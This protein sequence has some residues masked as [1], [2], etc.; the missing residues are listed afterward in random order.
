MDNFKYIWFSLLLLA[1]QQRLPAQSIVINEIHYSPSSDQGND[2]DYEFIELYNASGS[3]VNIADYYFSGITYTFA[4]G[5]TLAAGAFLVVAR[6]GNNYSESV[7]WTSGALTNGG[8]T[9][10]LY[11][12]SGNTIDQV[13]YD[14]TSPWP[15]PA[16]NDGPSL[17]LKD[18]STNNSLGSN[19]TYSYHLGGTPGYANQSIRLAGSEGWR[20]LSLPL[21]SKTYDNLLSV[22]WTQGFTGADATDGTANVYTYNGSSW[23]SISDQADTPTTGA[24]FLVYVF[25][26][27]NNDNSAEGFPKTISLSG[28][29]HTATVSVT[30]AENTW[31]FL[32]NPFTHSIDAD[33][34]SLGGS[35]SGTNDK[36][37]TVVYVWDNASGAF[38]SYDASTD[39][40]TLAGGLIEPFQGFFIQ[41]KSGGTQ[42]DFKSSSKAISSGN[43]YKIAAYPQIM[44]EAS[45]GVFID[46]VILNL[47]SSSSLISKGA[48]K[49]KPL[50]D[51]ERVLL[52][53]YD[54]SVPMEIMNFSLGDTIQTIAIDAFKIDANWA[55]KPG[56]VTLNWKLN[57]IPENLTIQLLD[58]KTGRAINLKEIGSVS[59]NNGHVDSP[60]F[61]KNNIGSIPRYRSP[62]FELFIIPNILLGAQTFLKEF[63]LF[64]AYP[65]PF[66][67]TT[68]IE[69]ELGNGG[70]VKMD[71]YNIRGQKIDSIINEVFPAG[72]HSVRWNRNHF[73]SGIYFCQL[74]AGSTIKVNKLVLIK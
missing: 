15:T 13:T 19:W 18:A 10:T 4:T 71:V 63:D 14:N 69:F 28:S 20:M 17:E 62:R 65:N 32:G 53:I 55:I 50:D 36:Y 54:D 51:R 70:I 38:K 48:L 43:F 16:D 11:D 44:I 64:P 61:D 74:Q 24:G 9:L 73:P 7:E 26:D 22:L 5:T 46:G 21:Q 39:S 52:S 40:G 3:S 41:S 49:L 56:P 37:E 31:N 34:L 30:T 6:N 58:R 57:N 68:T 29:E 45:S 23:S 25:S 2:T 72:S 42:F 27:D 12:G 67:S 33:K 1:F 60:A 66:N 35:G 47:I 59:F 8:E